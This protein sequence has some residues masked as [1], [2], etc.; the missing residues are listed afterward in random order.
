MPRSLLHYN[1]YLTRCDDKFPAPET[2]DKRLLQSITILTSAHATKSRK[3]QDFIP[4]YTR[5]LVCQGLLYKLTRT[6][7]GAKLKTRTVFFC[8][9]S[10]LDSH[11]VSSNPNEK[12]ERGRT[13]QR[14]PRSCATHRSVRRIHWELA[15]S[16]YLACCISVLD[17]LWT[18]MSPSTQNNLAASL[19]VPLWTSTSTC[20]TP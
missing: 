5:Y 13:L 14:S 1:R 11:I 10:C 12:W 15:K 7:E 16:R 8:V 17:A 2:H 9:N 6:C 20:Q 4:H 19:S 18:S 3:F